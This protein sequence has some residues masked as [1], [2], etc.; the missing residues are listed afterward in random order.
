M[1]F[2]QSKG[3]PAFNRYQIRS[4][5]GI[6]RYW[7][8]MALAHFICCVG[9]GENLPFEKGYACFQKHLQIERIEYFYLFGAKHISLEKV[10]SV[11]G[12]I[13]LR[14]FQI[15]SFIVLIHKMSQ[16]LCLAQVSSFFLI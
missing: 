13:I 1:F 5:R 6:W 4:A 8:L 10:L 12:R 3:K 2:R 16:T 11:A 7:L 14:I 15:C 9:T